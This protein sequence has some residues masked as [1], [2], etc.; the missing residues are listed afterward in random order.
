M[1]LDS[2]LSGAGNLLLP[3]QKGRGRQASSSQGE[4]EE[5]VGALQQVDG[6]QTAKPTKICHRGGLL[7]LRSPVGETNARATRARQEHQRRKPH[8]HLLW[9]LFQE[10][11]GPWA[12][13]GGED[14]RRTRGPRRAAGG[15]R[16]HPRRGGARRLRCACWLWCGNVFPGPPRPWAVGVR[17]GRHVG[18][19]MPLGLEIPVGEERS[20]S[21]ARR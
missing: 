13:W 17:F 2:L 14:E 3:G 8:G 7:E 6:P 21:A 15:R 19:K 10:G 11:G 9:N 1:L 20:R 18:G 12:P 16:A 5:V 4:G